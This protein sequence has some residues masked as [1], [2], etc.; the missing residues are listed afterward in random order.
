MAQQLVIE[1][2]L[3]AGFAV[4][5]RVGAAIRMG[6]TAAMSVS[7]SVSMSMPKTPTIARSR[8]T[9][10]V[11]HGVHQPQRLCS[12]QQG[13]QAQRTPGPQGLA[14]TL[15]HFNWRPG[16]LMQRQPKAQGQPASRAPSAA[17]TE[18]RCPDR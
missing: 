17:G 14:Q 15:H 1:P 6:M 9:L 7:V 2:A 8:R 18:F 12:Q 11:G 16:P 5:V 4:G 10:G 3:G 13:R